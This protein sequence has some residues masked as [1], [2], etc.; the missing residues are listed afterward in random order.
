MNLKKI[1]RLGV[2]GV[3]QDE[4]CVALVTFKHGDASEVEHTLKL[5]K[6]KLLI[7][8]LTSGVS[9]IPKDCVPDLLMRFYRSGNSLRD[10]WLTRRD[11][12][13]LSFKARLEVRWLKF[14]RYLKNNSDI[15]WPSLLFGVPIFLLV[16]A[17]VWAYI[18]D[19]AFAQGEHQK[20]QV[21]LESCQKRGTALIKGADYRT[22]YVCPDGQFHV[23]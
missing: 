16:G 5:M 18:D 13:L 21:N 11:L 1:W 19:H 6:A 15:I 20:H 8:D 17:M 14:E 9:T 2:R 12:N 7:P 23:R 22:I 10:D 3:E 4:V